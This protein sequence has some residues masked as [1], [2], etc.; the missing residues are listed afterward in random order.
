MRTGLGWDLL[1]L[2]A[3]LLP[4]AGIVAPLASGPDRQAAVVRTGRWGCLAATLAWVVLLAAGAAP[5]LGALDPAP[6]AM[7]AAAAAALLAASVARG[8]GAG[9]ALAPIAAAGLGLGVAIVD[10]PN[11]PETAARLALLVLA[12][13]G[14]AAVAVAASSRVRALAPVRLVVPVALLVVLRAATLL[15]A[16]TGPRAVLAGGAV[17]AIGAGVAGLAATWRPWTGALAAVLLVPAAAL[18]PVVAARPAAGLLAAGA[19]LGATGA[20]RWTLAASAPGLALLATAAAD[21]PAPPVDRAAQLTWVAGVVAAAVG[22]AWAATR[23]AA[24]VGAPDDPPTPEVQVAAGVVAAWLLVAPSSWRW[25]VPEASLL[26][27]WDRAAAVGV[28]AAAIAAAAA[29]VRGL[30]PGRPSPDRDRTAE[31]L[32]G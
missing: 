20:G 25:A 17:A 3:L 19:V 26:V 27:A 7:A 14:L 28:A 13:G 16:A 11:G 29:A 31:G 9:P 8:P 18:A 22:L 30:R 12:A 1:A 23:P 5:E 32:A 24:G 10:E 2:A 6:L 21:V 15:P 4:A